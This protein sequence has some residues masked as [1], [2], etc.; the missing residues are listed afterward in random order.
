MKGQTGIWI[1]GKKAI[2]VHF[3]RDTQVVDV[4]ESEVEYRQRIPGEGRE[5]TRQGDHIMNNETANEERIHHERKHFFQ[6]VA[7][8]LN[9]EFDI[10]IFGPAQTK[11]E[12]IRFL[13]DDHDFDTELIAIKPAD[14]MTNNQFAD[15]VN[16][17]FNKVVA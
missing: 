15:L 2:I 16:N 10:V 3:F 11:H 6:K 14:S 5:F 17:Y 8:K 9:P 4:L 7:Q 13:A 12:L 1:D